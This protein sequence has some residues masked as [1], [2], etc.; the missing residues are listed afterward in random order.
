MKNGGASER[1]RPS[2]YLK[3]KRSMKTG[4]LKHLFLLIVATGLFACSSSDDEVQATP[5]TLSETEVSV[6]CD[7][8]WY[9]LTV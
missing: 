2:F 5:V 7:A 6:D 9:S 8:T 3:E 1:T 4:V